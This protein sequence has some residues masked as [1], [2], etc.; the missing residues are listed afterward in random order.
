[1]NCA[2][3]FF[4]AACLSVAGCAVGPNYKTPTTALAQNYFEA[5]R[6]GTTNAPVSEWWKTFHDPELDK[7]IQET[8]RHNYDLRAAYARVRES[9][10]QRNIAAADLFPKVDAD[11]GYAFA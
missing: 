2:R 8:L 5:G 1:M 4:L 6:T 10:F 3:L 11:G 9:R 7:L